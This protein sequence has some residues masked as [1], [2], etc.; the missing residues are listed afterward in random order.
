LIGSRQGFTPT[1]QCISTQSD[2]NTHDSISQYT[3]HHG[4][5]GL[6]AEG[7]FSRTPRSLP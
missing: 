4:F 3:A 1:K 6:R 7:V 2:D 5:Y